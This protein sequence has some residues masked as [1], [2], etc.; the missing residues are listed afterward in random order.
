MG[1]VVRVC[2][3]CWIAGFTH[4]IR[5]C[6]C[7]HCVPLLVAVVVGFDCDV[8]VCGLLVGWYGLLDGSFN[9][10]VVL[11]CSGVSLFTLFGVASWLCGFV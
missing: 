4:A 2:L 6:S 7:A 1:F 8:L 9:S 11:V 5:L 3:C 10:V